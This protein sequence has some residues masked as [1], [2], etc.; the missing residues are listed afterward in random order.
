V[1]GLSRALNENG[2]A[3]STVVLASAEEAL[4]LARQVVRGAS[5]GSS[6]LSLIGEFV[7]PPAEGPPTRDFQTLHFDFG[8]PLDPKVE[9]DVAGYTALYV[10][11]EATKVTAVTRLVPVKGLLGQR[12]WPGRRELIER[13]QDYGRTHGSWDDS[14]G[15][16]EGSLARIVEAAGA[17]PPVLPDVKAPGFLCGMEFDSRHSEQMFFRNHGLD[18]AGVQIEVELQPGELLIFDNVAFAHGRR[19]CRQPGELRQWVFGRRLTPGEQR[20]VR[21]ALL[22]AFDGPERGC[23]VGTTCHGV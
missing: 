1:D 11:A 21:D 5:S 7:I 23:G 22:D 2:Y 19:G 12:A 14:R 13:L 16:T 17:R 8:I 6:P 18:L 15:Y 9:Q 3:P 4:E 20:E 10:P